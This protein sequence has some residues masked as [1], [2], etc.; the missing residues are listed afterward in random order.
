MVRL[1]GILAFGL[2]LSVAGCG[3][4]QAPSDDKAL[5]S[6]SMTAFIPQV[7]VATL[8]PQA[9]NLVER[10]QQTVDAMPVVEDSAP[11]DFSSEIQRRVQRDQTVRRALDAVIELP[12]AQRGQAS[13]AIRNIMIRIDTENTAWLKTRLPEDGWFLISRD[14]PRA[15]SVAF[16]LV[17]HSDDLVLMQDVLARMKP[18]VGTSEL[19]GQEYALL[20]DRVALMSGQPQRYGSQ[21]GCDDGRI[22]FQNLE[23]PDDVE[24]RRRGLGFTETLDIYAARFPD[25]GAPCGS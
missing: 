15:A 5:P 20:F 7:D 24:A 1:F 12:E 21:I 11:G 6:F 23:E 2:L 9:R 4:S 10:T 16:L 14:G 25:F 19:R 18:L 3:P 17:Q 13:F 8:P 22:G